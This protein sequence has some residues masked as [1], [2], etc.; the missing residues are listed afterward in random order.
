MRWVA[1]PVKGLNNGVETI[2]VNH[3][4][5]MILVLSAVESVGSAVA[6]L[7]KTEISM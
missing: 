3:K 1:R 2:V 4:D 7:T 5:A 6:L